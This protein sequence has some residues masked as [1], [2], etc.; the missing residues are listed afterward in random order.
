[1]P[2]MVVFF[3]YSTIEDNLKE[4]YIDVQ[5]QKYTLLCKVL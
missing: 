1:M 2:D 3:S 5:V 4:I